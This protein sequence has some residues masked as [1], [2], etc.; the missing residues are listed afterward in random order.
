L[1]PEI[2]KNLPWIRTLG[3]KHRVLDPDS[4]HGDYSIFLSL[5]NKK[6]LF[7]KDLEPRTNKIDKKEAIAAKRALLFNIIFVY[8][9][10]LSFFN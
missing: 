6:I 7:L 1:G 9:F 10:N 8:L 3:P 2:Q 5:I 4:Q